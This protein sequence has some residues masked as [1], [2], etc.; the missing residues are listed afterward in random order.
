MQC[1]SVRASSREDLQSACNLEKAGLDAAI[2]VHIF[3]E[4]KH[5]V[6]AAASNCALQGS[7]AQQ[8][9]KLCCT[10]GC[11]PFDLLAEVVSLQRE[12]KGELGEIKC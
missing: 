6:I 8:S 7:W 10:V 2:Q 4:A 3:N 5:A 11:W 12:R 9:P 1:L